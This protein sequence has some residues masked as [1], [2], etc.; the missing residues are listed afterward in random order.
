MLGSRK[1]ILLLLVLIFG[2]NQVVELSGIALP[3]LHEYLD[4]VLCLPIVLSVILVIHR[5]FRLQSSEYILPFS[6]VLLSLLV[7]AT[8]FEAV[9]PIASSRFVGDPI[10][11]LAYILGA[12][13]FLR[14]INVPQ[15]CPR[16]A[17]SVDQIH[18]L[19]YPR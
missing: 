14:Y 9:L 3:I 7:I 6:H 2:L 10:D 11:V 19:W 5:R 17:G 4:D 15:L 16:I 13:F 18:R 1:N 12:L 8:L